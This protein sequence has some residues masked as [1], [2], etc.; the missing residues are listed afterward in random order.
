MRSSNQTW[1]LTEDDLDHRRHRPVVKTLVSQCQQTL[2]RTINDET[3][4]R[5]LVGT[6]YGFEWRARWT[7]TFLVHARSWIS[8]QMIGTHWMNFWEEWYS[9]SLARKVK[10]CRGHRFLVAIRHGRSFYTAWERRL[11]FVR[12]PSAL[13]SHWIFSSF[14][15]SPIYLQNDSS[16]D[17]TSSFLLLLV[18]VLLSLLRVHISRQANRETNIRAKSEGRKRNIPFHRYT[19]A[20]LRGCAQLFHVLHIDPFD[21]QYGSAESQGISDQPFRTLRLFPSFCWFS[22]TVCVEIWRGQ[23]RTLILVVSCVWPI[24]TYRRSLTPD[25]FER[26]PLN[27]VSTRAEKTCCEKRCH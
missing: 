1:D 24:K 12:L 10:L 22:S 16:S 21:D 8:S 7:T 26:P 4:K 23:R 9:G 13:S 14:P 25:S 6:T 20:Y 5:S 11:S 17:V 19:T 27:K 2:F 18:L 15:L 3:A